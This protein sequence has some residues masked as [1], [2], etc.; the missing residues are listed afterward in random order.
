MN[1]YCAVIEIKPDSLEKY[2]SLHKEIHKG[3]HKELL[4]VIADSG[5]K[6]E[7]IFMYKN[8]AIVY[9]EAEDLDACYKYQQKFK[10]YEEWHVLMMPL[11][12]AKYELTGSGNFAIPMV[13][14]V[15]DLRE[16]LE[17]M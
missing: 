5:V 11:F 8:L 2:V 17:Q 13:E 15:F 12:E 4:K 7:A 10:V 3:P 14:K 1:K 6:E 9:F 16:Q